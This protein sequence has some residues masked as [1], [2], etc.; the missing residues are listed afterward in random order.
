VTCEAH[1]VEVAELEADNDA[2]SEVLDVG[3]GEDIS[4]GEK[5]AIVA[6]V[7]V[8]CTAATDDSGV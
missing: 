6:S 8:D 4:D 3:A 7:N 1:G 2:A 5:L